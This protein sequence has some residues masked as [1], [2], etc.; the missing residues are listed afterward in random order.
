MTQQAEFM[1]AVGDLLQAGKINGGHLT[2]EEIGRCFSDMELSEQ[3]M[4]HICS[5]IEKQGIVIENRV[6]KGEEDPFVLMDADLDNPLDKEMVRIYKKE[7]SRA[8]SLS[9]DQ[10][11]LLVQR[12]AAGDRNARNLLIEGNLGLAIRLAGEYKG[13]G[14]LFCDLIQE[15]NIGLMMAINAFEP[16]VDG[17]FADFKEKMIRQQIETALAEYSQSTRSAK[18]M[19]SRINEMNGV[20]TVFAR[21]YE[22]EASP[23]ELAERMGISEDEVRLLMKTS[24]DAIAVLDQGK[25]D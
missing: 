23:K 5:Y 19:A 10:E 12:M 21:E 11:N 9:P 25:I 16:E 1:E 7:A 13:Q 22:R 15:S 4:D 17:A 14:L 3:Q 24:L 20:A 8:R 6:K 2:M 18:K